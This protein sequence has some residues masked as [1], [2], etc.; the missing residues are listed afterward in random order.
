MNDEIGLFQVTEF[1]S[2]FHDDLQSSTMII[3]S[4]LKWR[5]LHCDRD[6]SLLNGSSR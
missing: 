1:A 5:G 4:N 3:E 2:L 6:L